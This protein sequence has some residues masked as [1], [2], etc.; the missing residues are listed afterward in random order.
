MQILDFLSL[1]IGPT[2]ELGLDP[3]S[4]QDL[5]SHTAANVQTAS[6]QN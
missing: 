6:Q 1:Q 2:L 4:L 5:G 3:H